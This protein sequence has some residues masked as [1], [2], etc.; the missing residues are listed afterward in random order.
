[1]S[2]ND[3]ALA[4]VN[5]TA[6]A[7]YGERDEVNEITDRLLA[8]HPQAQQ[9]G[10][11]GMRAVAQLAIMCGA[12]P[13]PAAGEIHV[14]PDRDG[15]P[16]VDLGVAYYRRKASEKDT[17]VWVEGGDPRKMTDSEREYY[18]IEETAV[19]GICR[20]F[21]LSEYQKL[22][23]LGVPWQPA[24]QM[25]AREA[26]AVVTYEEMFYVRDTKYNKAGDPR[27]PPT[28]QTWQVVAN[29]RAEK[30]FYR[31]KSLVD[32]TLTDRIQEHANYALKQLRYEMRE[33]SLV[34]PSEEV[35]GLALEQINDE[36]Y[37]RQDAIEGD[38][39]PVEETAE[40]PEQPT[41]DAFAQDIMSASTYAQFYA[42]CAKHI[43]RY[44]NT[45]AVKGV[46]K[47]LGITI[48]K[49]AAERVAQA[50]AVARYAELRDAGMD[51]DA[52]LARL[53]EG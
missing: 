36:L 35:R 10:V 25:L 26:F 31:M 27:K 34:E 23:E 46:V 49:D 6:I 41:P 21:L 13:L 52:A 8:L 44:D 51:Q 14:W 2:N 18:N 30:A 12:N 28:A 20:G 3:R 11:K 9:I 42:A 50:R 38:F 43:G 33:Q 45:H 48:S 39:E 4:T 29:K 5:G 1:M 17:V 47:L 40:A 16:V 24:Q 19:A 53:S 7:A 22:L 37:G 15:R 32:T